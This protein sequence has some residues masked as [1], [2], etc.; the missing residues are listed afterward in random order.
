MTIAI[1]IIDSQDTLTPIDRMLN[2]QPDFDI[3]DVVES[4]Q[5]ALVRLR[6][7]EIDV[8]LYSIGSLAKDWAEIC[9]KMT[10]QHPVQVI[11][12]AAHVDQ[13]D[14]KQAVQAGA[15]Y[16]LLS[17]FDHIELGDIIRRISQT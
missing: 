10:A 16:F 14:M 6:Q 13:N 9:S 15:R 4:G 12:M 7:Y 3:I 2:T 1:L 5:D 11:I 17:P 8:V